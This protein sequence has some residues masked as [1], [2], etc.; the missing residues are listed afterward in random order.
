[1][2]LPFFILVKLNRVF[3][4][5]I[6][7]LVCAVLAC[8]ESYIKSF[9]DFIF[10]YELKQAAPGKLEQP[11]HHIVINNSTTRPWTVTSLRAFKIFEYFYNSIY[12]LTNSKRK[13]KA[14]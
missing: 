11:S 3:D 5:L 4:K 2:A 8:A 6:R 10:V 12:A 1:M 14:F 9:N 7:V 13:E